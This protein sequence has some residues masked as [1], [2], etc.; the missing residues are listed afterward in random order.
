MS[1]RIY[2]VN[3]NSVITDQADAESNKRSLILS[4]VV[5]ITLFSMGLPLLIIGSISTAEDRLAMLIPGAILFVV[6]AFVTIVAAVK[7]ATTSEQ[8]IA[9]Q[10]R[11]SGI[12]ILEAVPGKPVRF[13]INNSPSNNDA[14]VGIY[15]VNA[16]DVEHGDQWGWLRDKHM[17][18]ASLPGQ[19]EGRWSIRVF[20][21]GG[22]T[23]H[24]RVD[25]DIVRSQVLHS[26]VVHSQVLGKCEFIS[27]SEYDEVWN[28]KGSGAK[29]D[30]S[31]WRARV[32]AGCH[33]LGMTAKLGHSRPTFPTLVIR[34]GDSYIAP[35]ER[36]DLV[37]WQERGKRRF[38][39]WRPIPPPG[40]V[41]LGDVGTMSEHPPSPRDVVCVALECLGPNKQPLG[42]QIWNDRG[43]GAPK[44]G[45]FFAQPGGTGL[46]RCSDDDTHNR[47]HGEFYLPGTMSRQHG[48]IPE[49]TETR[50]DQHLHDPEKA[51]EFARA[52]GLNVGG[53]GHPFVGNWQTKG[54]YAYRSGQYNGI[55]YFGSGGSEHERLA[56]PSESEKYRPWN[57]DDPKIPEDIRQKLIRLEDRMNRTRQPSTKPLSRDMLRGENILVSDHSK[58]E[59]NGIYTIQNNEINGKPWFKNNLGCILYFYNANSG[60]GPSWS[61]DDRSQDGT[62]DWFRGGWIEPPNSGG[63]P[64]G[65]R[66]WA[67]LETHRRFEIKIESVSIPDESS[68]PILN[69]DGRKYVFAHEHNGWHWHN[70][71]ARAMGGHLASITNGIENE[72]ITRISGGAP[73]WIGGIRKGSGNGPG[74]NHWYWSDGRPWSYTNWHPGEPNNSG[75]GENRVHLGLQAPGTWNDVPDQWHG[76]AV[77]VLSAE[78]SPSTTSSKTIEILEAVP[79][80]PVRFK[81]NNRPISNDAWVGIYPSNASDHEHGEQGNRWHWIRDIDVNN[82]SLPAQSEGNWS[83][84]VFSDGG[85]SLYHREDFEIERIPFGEQLKIKQEIQE[86]KEEMSEQIKEKMEE[87][88]EKLPE[89]IKETKSFQEMKSTVENTVESLD[90]KANQAIEEVIVESTEQMEQVQE[91]VLLSLEDSISKLN[92]TLERLDKAV[93]TKD[94]ENIIS[95]LSGSQM[96]LNLTIDRID[97]T[98]GYGIDEAFRGGKTIVGN[99]EGIPHSV[100]IKVPESMNDF[101]SGLEKGQTIEQKVTLSTFNSVRKMLEFVIDK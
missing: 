84:R 34:A 15:P 76:P 58:P 45:A 67:I 12:D 82:A 44:D 23:L 24:D 13:R 69:S 61:L 51:A 59:Y 2:S 94:R 10:R 32:P 93:M 36:F 80:K 90:E 87:V 78:T 40:Y 37:W 1:S 74:A 62:N 48:N 39:C 81:I 41:S 71:R 4:F 52:L 55:A 9:Q 42:E 75:G 64:L 53:A 27:I 11:G 5:G 50:H 63:L 21:D 91:K 26:Q 47:P 49:E 101:A 85:F 66:S 6:G 56:Y 79:G 17:D 54:F 20:S 73:V 8:D 97:N 38:W 65:T 57:R 89:E 3:P 46:F 19:S 14:W 68:E 83:V 29:Q 35:P 72:Q 60:G 100:S 96:N 88:E 30:V 95:E 70:E 43:G 33:L 25:F 92:D 31:V 98:I 18:N 77:Y 7:K 86:K 22:Y 28:D 16:K 99:I